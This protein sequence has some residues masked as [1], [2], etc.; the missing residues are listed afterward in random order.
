M[1]LFTGEIAEGL[2][3]FKPQSFEF[4]NDTENCTVCFSEMAS[5]LGADLIVV[6]LMALMED[7]AI[8]TAFCM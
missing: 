1:L 7:I 5:E 4:N 6:P 3:E 8:C 2:P